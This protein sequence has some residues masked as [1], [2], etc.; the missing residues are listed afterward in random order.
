MYVSIFCKLINLKKVY[1]YIYNMSD[2]VKKE[3]NKVGND[4]LEQDKDKMITETFKG[5]M[6][7]FSTFRTEI[8]RMQT[9]FRIL[10]KTVQR[11]LRTLR[12]E[13]SKSK[14]RG[15]RAPSGF[16]TPK[17]IS[18]ELCVFMEKEKGA[19]VARTEVTQYIIEYIKSN[20]LAK[21]RYIHPDNKLKAL[22]NV[23]DEDEVTYFNL[24]RYMNQ[25]FQTNSDQV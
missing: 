21:S 17:R 22:L 3:T 24:Q 2:K 16:A 13:V 5:I 4:T 8:T 10:E 18:D 20:D 12:K 19:A 6:S 7:S 1:I 23:K 9:Q 11:E 14:N 15:N 25:H